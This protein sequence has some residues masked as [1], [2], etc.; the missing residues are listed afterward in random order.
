M[1]SSDSAAKSSDSALLTTPTENYTFWGVK[2]VIV[3]PQRYNFPKVLTSYPEKYR[4]PLYLFIYVYMNVVLIIHDYVQYIRT[5][6]N[7]I[8]ALRISIK[9]KLVH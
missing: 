3:I 8:Q 2:Y 5:G 7:W 9:I 4:G 1:T 6:T